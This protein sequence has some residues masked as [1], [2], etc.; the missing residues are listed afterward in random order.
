MTNFAQQCS[1]EFLLQLIFVFSSVE[2]KIQSFPIKTK[3][4]IRFSRIS[5]LTFFRITPYNKLH[6]IIIT[7]VVC[8]FGFFKFLTLQLIFN[9]I[10]LKFHFTYAKKHERY[11]AAEVL[12]IIK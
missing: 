6:L 5:Y 12:L 9:N 3:L 2:I 4:N 11:S 7:F 1:S 10:Y 8:C